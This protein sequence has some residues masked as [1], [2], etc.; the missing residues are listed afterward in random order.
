MLNA[1]P[2][3]FF[4]K[5]VGIIEIVLSL[6]MFFMHVNIDTAVTIGTCVGFGFILLSFYITDTEIEENVERWTV[7]S[8]LV[9]L[10]P[11]TGIYIITVCSVHGKQYRSGCHP[12]RVHRRKHRGNLYIFHEI[13]SIAK[14]PTANPGSNLYIFHKNR[15]PA[16]I[17]DRFQN[18]NKWYF[19]RVQ[20]FRKNV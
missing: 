14:N 3:G 15:L 8:L 20:L 13:S 12:S 4:F 16:K 17:S 11:F 7:N 19:S 18:N 2:L 5:I 6:V 1:S 9:L 10:T